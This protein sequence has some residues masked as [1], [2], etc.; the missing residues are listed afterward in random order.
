MMFP[1]KNLIK[2]KNKIDRIY[3]EDKLIRGKKEDPKI[4]QAMYEEE[5]TKTTKFRCW[6]RK[7]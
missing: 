4:Y 2:I 3:F 1:W 6:R 7:S 5:V